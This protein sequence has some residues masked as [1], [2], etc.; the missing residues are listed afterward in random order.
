M[1]FSTDIYLHGIVIHVDPHGW[2]VLQS[3]LELGS[4]SLLL[5]SAFGLLGVAV[6]L[7]GSPV[8]RYIDR[9]L[10]PQPPLVPDFYCTC[11][12]V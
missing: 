10:L 1:P 3:M 12:Y 4:G 7:A 2:N 11:S 5:V 6:V 9:W 8:G